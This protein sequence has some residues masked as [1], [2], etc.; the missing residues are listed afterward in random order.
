MPEMHGRPEKHVMSAMSVIVEM[1]GITGT[2]H[3]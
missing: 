2:P 1:P 3:S